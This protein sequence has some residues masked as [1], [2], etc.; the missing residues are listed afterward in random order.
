MRKWILAT[1]RMELKWALTG[2]MGS[3]KGNREGNA[4]WKSTGRGAYASIYLNSTR[5][6]QNGGGHMHGYG[7]YDGVKLSIPY[8]TRDDHHSER[9]EITVDLRRYLSVGWGFLLL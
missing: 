3:G 5:A 9:R 2:M 6:V 8:P 7:M 4:R 1:A